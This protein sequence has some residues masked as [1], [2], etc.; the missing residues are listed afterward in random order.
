MSTYQNRVQL[1]DEDNLDYE[2]ADQRRADPCR[3]IHQQQQRFAVLM[4]Y[5]N[6][7]TTEDKLGLLLCLS[8][9]YI[10]FGPQP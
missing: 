1:R 7:L 5:C 10:R 3:R 4:D 9:A 2:S 8:F 6:V